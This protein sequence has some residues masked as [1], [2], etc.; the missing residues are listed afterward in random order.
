MTNRGLLVIFLLLISYFSYAQDGF[1]RGTVFDETG[2]SMPGVNVILDGT[3]IGAMTDLDGKFNIKVAPGTYTLKASFI[4]Y[5]TITIS[6]I[7][8]KAGEVSLYDNLKLQPSS[9]ILNDVKVVAK[10]V[11]NT[12][13]AVTAMR[14]K[15]PVLMNGISA[16]ALRKTGDSD[17]ASSIKRVSGVSVSGGK[18]VYVR[19]LGDRYSKTILNG[20]EIPGLDPDRNSIQMDIFPTNIINNIVVYKSA[21]AEL[22]ADF[23]GGIVNLELKDFP[24]EKMGKIS[25]STSY[26][27]AMHFNKDYL[28]YEGGKTD[29]LGFDDGTRE[30]PAINNI[31]DR[32]DAITG[33]NGGMDRYQEILKSFNP[34]MAAFKKSSLM[35]ASMSFDFGNQKTKEKYSIG[36]N[37]SF[38]YKNET[39]FYKDAE[40]GRYDKNEDNSAFELRRLSSKVGDIGV[41]NVLLSGLAGIAFKSQNSKYR[42]NLL[43]IQNGESKASI[44]DQIRTDNGTEY[45]AFIHNLE[46]EQ[47]SLSNLLIDGKS[48][49]NDAKWELVWKISPTFSS[50]SDPDIRTTRYTKDEEQESYI[51]QGGAGDFPKRIWRDL[52]EYNISGLANVTKKYTFKGEPAKLKFGASHTYKERDF[53]IRKFQIIPENFES[54]TENPDELFYEENLWPINGDIS[55]GTYYQASFLP[56]NRNQFNSNVSSSATYISTE[57]KPFNTLSV[58]AGVR[59]E[60][61]LQKYTGEGQ[62]TNELITLNNDQVINDLDI[63]PTLNLIYNLNEKQNLRFSYYSTIARPSFKEMSYAQIFDP[64]TG[65][66]F[67]GGLYEEVDNNGNVIWDGNLVSTSINNIDFRW[68]KFFERAQLISFSAFYK[69]FKNPIEMF[70][71]ISKANSFQPRNVGDGTLLGLEFEVNHNLEFISSRLENLNFVSNFTYTHSKILMTDTEYQSRLA[72]AREGE[73]IEKYRDMAGMSPYIINSGLQYNG[74]AET[75]LDGLEL[76]LYYNVQGKALEVVGILNRPDIYTKPFHSLNFNANYNFGKDKKMALGLKI[77]NILDSRKVSV[78]ESYNATKQYFSNLYLGRTVTFKWSYKLFS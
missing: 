28:T 48:T 27:P 56:N 11:R 75:K 32:I 62:S 21:N 31:P 42:I 29:F 23:T 50:I 33:D 55:Q 9:I 20:L 7:N 64:I 70:Q 19:G 18:Y 58:V 52:K 2:F 69:M 72:N 74:K 24:E 34:H 25:V 67:N 76:G 47:R 16:V 61:Y 35:D 5:E 66:E 37:L 77:S 6:N 40:Y 30:I 4:S 68:E 63:F 71:F 65:N 53:V 14:K 15:S 26:N 78:F 43:H 22:P 17:A 1:I 51:I 8:V 60:Y 59:A 54:F 39:D 44:V 57:L 10:R 46:Y 12:E 38:S 45:Q 3:T 49:F 36:Y 13:T 41:N 73:S